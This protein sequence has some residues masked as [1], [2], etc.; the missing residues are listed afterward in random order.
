MLPGYFGER[1][2]PYCS[3]IRIREV[4]PLKSGKGLLRVEFFN[5]LYA[6]G[7]QDFALDLKVLKRASNYLLADLPYDPERSAV[8]GHIEFSWLES[9][10]PKLLAAHPPA[11]YS[12]VSVYLDG[13]FG[14]ARAA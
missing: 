3:P 10:C 4:H 7:V 11:S 2:T 13:I 14:S 1:M 5:A 9:F 6:E 8:I 12:S